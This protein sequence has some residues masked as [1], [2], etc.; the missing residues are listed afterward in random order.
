MFERWALVFADFIKKANPDETEPHDVLVFGFTIL[1][2]LLFTFTLIIMS[3]WLLDIPFLTLQVAFSFMLLRIL[4][5]GAHLEH[6]LA[7]SL[8][9]FSLLF[10]FVWLPVSNIL[11]TIYITIILINLL[12]FAPYYETHQVKHSAKWERKKKL[13]ALLWVLISL[14]IYFLYDQT[15]LVIGALLQALLLTPAGIKLTHK[16]NTFSSKGGEIHE[17]NS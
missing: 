6:S 12:C 15:G 9:S 8:T 5:G 10:V 14:V 17:K 4:T 13:V 7:C 2:N 3:G 1:F 16:L 11:I